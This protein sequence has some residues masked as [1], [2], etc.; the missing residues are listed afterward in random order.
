MEYIKDLVFNYVMASAFLGWFFAQ[1]IKV[2]IALPKAYMSL[3]TN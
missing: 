3:S 2:F 1:V